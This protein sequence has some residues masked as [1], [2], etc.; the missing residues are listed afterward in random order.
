MDW[1]KSAERRRGFA[2]ACV[3]LKRQGAM[4]PAFWNYETQLNGTLINP[5]IL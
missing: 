1:R 3:G 5:H 4:E 2:D